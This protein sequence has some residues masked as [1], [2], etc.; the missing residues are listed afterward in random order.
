M[1]RQK[2]LRVSAHENIEQTEMAL[3]HFSNALITMWSEDDKFFILYL[4]QMCLVIDRHLPPWIRILRL[5]FP[6][7]VFWRVAFA[8]VMLLI[9]ALIPMTYWFTVIVVF[10]IAVGIRDWIGYQP[11]NALNHLEVL[12]DLPAPSCIV[13]E[14]ECLLR[15][16][17]SEDNT[18]D[19]LHRLVYA[20]RFWATISRDTIYNE[21]DACIVRGD[22]LDL[23]R[24]Y[25]V[26]L[27]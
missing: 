24:L 25:N 9:G 19:R 1:K 3:S 16:H 21:T 23:R 10:V 14:L 27:Y 12:F 17:G 26:A 5:I 20:W 7:S 4:R 22:D 2:W 11:P 15:K 13:A 6:A 18:L 8:S